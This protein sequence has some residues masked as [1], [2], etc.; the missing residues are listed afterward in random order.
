MKL[1]RKFIGIEK[2]AD[3]FELACARLEA[4]NAQ[5]DLFLA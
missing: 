2:R 4:A 3:Y 5:P 1:G